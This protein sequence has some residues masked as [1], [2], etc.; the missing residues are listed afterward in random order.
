HALPTRRSSDLVY[1][2]FDLSSISGNLSNVK[3][4][5]FGSVPG[6]EQVSI[7]AYSVADTSWSESNITWNNKPAAGTTELAF[8]TV[9][10][11]TGAWYEWDLTAYVKAEKA[12]GRNLVSFALLNPNRNTQVPSFASDEA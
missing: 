5:L 6:G 8:V 12:A 9:L 10:G 4:R 1:L 11:A 7:S 3:L 2:T